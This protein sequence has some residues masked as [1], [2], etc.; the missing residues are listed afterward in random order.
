ML[1][2]LYCIFNFTY[3]YVRS[4]EALAQMQQKNFHDVG[5]GTQPSTDMQMSPE[6]MRTTG[7]VMSALIAVIGL[8]MMILASPIRRG[9]KGATV[10]G[11]VVTGI[12]GGL[13]LLATGMMAII[14]LVAPVMF[15][16]ACCFT[17]PLSLTIWTFVTMW[18]AIRAIGLI[19]QAAAMSQTRYA[20]AG[21]G[22]F[23]MQGAPGQVGGSPPV[24]SPTESASMSAPP[25]SPPAAAPMFMM[26]PAPSQPPPGSASPHLFGPAPFGIPPPP[27]ELPAGKY[28]YATRP[29]SPP[30]PAAAPPPPPPPQSPP[31][32]PPATG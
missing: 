26:P 24:Q 21:P 18:Q 6:E 20:A 17:V 28:G 2:A 32:E 23:P 7:L 1:I 15:G 9:S 25:A 27:D 13:L 19:Q 5:I 22:G 29:P 30:P 14:G 11:M 3:T 12:V 10:G 31:T 4:P 16:V 8:A